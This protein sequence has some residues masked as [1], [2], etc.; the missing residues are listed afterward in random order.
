MTL[1]RTLL[2]DYD[3]EAMYEADQVISSLFFVS[4]LLI[5]KLALLNMFIAIIVAHYNQ[6]RRENTN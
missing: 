1:L 4:Y 3:Y 2:L 6:Q 5:F